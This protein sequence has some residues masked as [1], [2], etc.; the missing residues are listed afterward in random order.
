LEAVPSG[1]AALERAV[2]VEEAT[3]AL[4]ND[5]E[6]QAALENAQAAGMAGGLVA[7]LV[8]KFVAQWLRRLL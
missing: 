8:Q 4:R 3:A 1:R 6:F 7:G 2:L 5:A